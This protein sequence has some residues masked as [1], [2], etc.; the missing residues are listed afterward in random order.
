MNVTA[1]Q[2]RVARLLGI[3][4]IDSQNDLNQI[5]RAVEGARSAGIQ[6]LDSQN[7]LRQIESY[8]SQGSSYE[9]GGSDYELERSDFESKLGQQE[10]YYQ[11]MLEKLKIQSAQQES[12]FKDK[13]KIMQEGF[14]TAQRTTLG[15]QARGTQQADYQLTAVAPSRLPGVGGFRRRGGGAST[16]FSAIGFTAPNTVQNKGRTLNV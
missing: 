5:N 3:Q 16:P 6:S 13:L 12:A 15:N 1:E 4:N 7:D 9:S 10:S 8:Y 11:G 2:R 14:D